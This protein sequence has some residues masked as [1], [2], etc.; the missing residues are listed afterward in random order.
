[1]VELDVESVLMI[2]VVLFIVHYMMN[3]CK[4]KEGLTAQGA[5]MKESCHA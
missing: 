3:N 1:M 2:V 5:P 4:I